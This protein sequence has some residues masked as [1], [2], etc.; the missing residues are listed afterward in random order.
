MSQKNAMDFDIAGDA[1]KVLREFAKIAK[2]QAK[3]TEDQAKSA[4]KSRGHASKSSSELMGMAKQY[5][6]VAAAVGVLK[7]AITAVLE[8]NQRMNDAINQNTLTLD[9]NFRKTANQLGIT[10]PDYLIEQTAPIARRLAIDL[11]AASDATRELGSQGVRAVDILHGGILEET[12]KAAVATGQRENLGEFAASMTGFLREQGKS[13]TK[14]SFGEL[15]LNL[16]SLFKS[17]VLQASDLTQLARLAPSASAAGMDQQT[18]LAM[19]TLAKESA[20][21]NAA[22]GETALRKLI[23]SLQSSQSFEGK[24]KQMLGK[25]GLTADDID[26]VGESISQVLDRLAEGLEILP[27]KQR[28]SFLKEVFGEEKMSAISGII[29]KRGRLGGLIESQQDVAGFRQALDVQTTGRS[30]MQ[31]RADIDDAMNEFETTEAFTAAAWRQA[32]TTHARQAG[33]GG[34]EIAARLKLFDVE[35]GLGGTPEAATQATTLALSSSFE[36][37]KAIMESQAGGFFSQEGAQG[38]QRE[39][40]DETK[41]LNDNMKILISTVGGEPVPEPDSTD[42]VDSD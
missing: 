25:A 29:G 8:E 9:Q 28:A 6:S 13:F 40:L 4:R 14:E 39:Q 5:L 22:Q 36:E 3:L 23:S 20:G 15:G 18:M 10:S 12:L 11:S 19:F 2:A 24:K 27:Q 38:I 7:T 42:L 26:L 33:A 30:A 1:S 34:I 31:T 35:L 16:F 21:N 41:K 32:I 17:N 37:I